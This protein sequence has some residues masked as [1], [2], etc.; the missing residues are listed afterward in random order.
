M[1]K[2]E[3]NYLFFYKKG[4]PFSQWFPCYFRIDNCSFNCTEQWMMYAKAV[5]F[6]DLEMA[7]QILE[8]KEP[9]RQ[10]ELGRM[11]KNFDD[12]VWKKDAKTIVY[13]G[14]YEKFSQNKYLRDQL[15]ATENKII[16]EANPHDS[17][18]GIGMSIDNPAIYDQKKW[19]GTNWL[20]EILMQV[21][22]D[23]LKENEQK[24]NQLLL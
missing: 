23:L 5:L 8:T 10:K 12:V 4:S 13:K 17:I 6:N 7:Q 24:T 21:R 18:W 2:I 16:V 11:V 1:M 3:N 22:V 20:G 19:I 9:I 14:N 15:F